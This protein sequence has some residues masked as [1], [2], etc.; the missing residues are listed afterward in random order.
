[1]AAFARGRYSMGDREA[2]PTPCHSTFS[3]VRDSIS[4]FGIIS[5]V[6]REKVKPKTAL[7]DLWQLYSNGEQVRQPV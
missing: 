4:T 1:M 2:P 6:A 3:P 5:T 7:L